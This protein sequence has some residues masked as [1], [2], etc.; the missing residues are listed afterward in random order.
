[1]EHTSDAQTDK[2][3]PQL[4][5]SSA[6][7][8]SAFSPNTPTH[9]IL[10]LQRLI[11]NRAVNRM[12]VQRDPNPVTQPHIQ[13]IHPQVVLWQDGNPPRVYD[14]S[15]RDLRL[16]QY[17][18][19]RGR[20]QIRFGVR[21]NGEYAY[22]TVTW[23]IRFEMASNSIQVEG[24]GSVQRQNGRDLPGVQVGAS[25]SGDTL[26]VEVAAQREGFGVVELLQVAFFNQEAGNARAPRQRN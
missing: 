4:S 22:Y 12:L 3:Q 23:Q 26:T 16:G 19:M 1:M 2:E 8:E 11:G 20:C 17:Q 15:S 5:Q 25:Q 7:T 18:D 14:L 10:Q 13:F 21:F 9:Q 6:S 24:G